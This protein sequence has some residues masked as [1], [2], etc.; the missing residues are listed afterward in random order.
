[1]DTH[2]HRASEL[3]RQSLGEAR[4]SIKALRPEA[5][6][7]GDLRTA[8]NT[9]MKQM[10]AGTPLRAEF[11]TQGNP[12]PLIQSTEENLLRIHQ[13]ILTNAM[14]HSGAKAI[15]ATL[16]FDEN[17]VRL[18]VRDDGVGFELLKNHDGL[19]LLGIR[20]RVNQMNGRLTIESH[21]GTG[22]RI[23]IALPIESHVDGARRA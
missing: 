1:M 10:T 8:L 12:R 16:W 3:A 23:A 14:K 9:L 19:G 13:E 4:R 18:E 11:T 20:E 7:N 6:E 15:Q 5:L 2:I 22:T 17:A 21:I